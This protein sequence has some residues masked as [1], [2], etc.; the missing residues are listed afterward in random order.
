VAKKP[1][2][3]IA[4]KPSTRSTERAVARSRKADPRINGNAVSHRNGRTTASTPRKP[5]RTET[6]RDVGDTKPAR[7]N[8]DAGRAIARNTSTPL[9]EKRRAPIAATQLV[10]PSGKA[11]RI[12]AGREEPDRPRRSKKLR[13]EKDTILRPLVPLPPPPVTSDSKPK[14]NQAG[15]S[16]RELDAFRATLL[17]KRRELLGDMSSMEREALQSGQ[18]SN[19]SNLPVHMADMGTDNYEQE[20]TLGLVEKDRQLLREI[21]HALAKIH[22]G[23]YG[24]CEGTGKPIKKERLEIQPWTRYSIEHARA[25]EKNMM[26]RR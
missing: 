23:T 24:I 18:G 10:K 19:L 21:N 13:R 7:V 3:S 11:A 12:E 9:N 2:K 26:I 4:K 6:R 1:A 20:F 22:D 5:D 17:A 25:L 16:T 8:P 14:K 15:L